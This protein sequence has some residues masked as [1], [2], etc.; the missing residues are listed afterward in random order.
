[1]RLGGYEHCQ[2]KLAYCSIY[3]KK[4]QGRAVNC[5]GSL[6]LDRADV[7]LSRRLGEA[8]SVP[9]MVGG[10]IDTGQNRQRYQEIKKAKGIKTKKIANGKS[11]YV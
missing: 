6:A 1:M 8:R 2:A 3:G 11:S 9:W 10:E 5:V 4:H 7:C